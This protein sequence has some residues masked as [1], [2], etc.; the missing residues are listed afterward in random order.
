MA[1]AEDGERAS[2]RSH[3]V[4]PSFE[5]CAEAVNGIGRPLAG[6]IHGWYEVSPKPEGAAI[7]APGTALEMDRAMNARIAQPNDHRNARAQ[8]PFVAVVLRH[9]QF[10]S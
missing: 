3:F 8:G 5:R 10:P 2:L 6:S 4:H 9:D 1:P 7:A